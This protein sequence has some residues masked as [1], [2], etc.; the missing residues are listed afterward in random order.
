[1][2]INSIKLSPTV[3][4]QEDEPWKY[5]TLHLDFHLLEVKELEREADL[6]SVLTKYTVQENSTPNIH[7]SKDPKNHTNGAA[8]VVHSSFNQGISRAKCTG[9]HLFMLCNHL[10]ILSLD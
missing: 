1:M 2:Q 9:I 3:I 8:F 5:L 7:G 4:I 10:L 6:V